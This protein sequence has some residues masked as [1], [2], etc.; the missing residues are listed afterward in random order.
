L[1]TTL[2]VLDD[3][4][5]HPGSSVYEAACPAHDDHKRSL[6]VKVGGAGQ[7][8]LFCLAFCRIPAITHVIRERQ[9]AK[10]RVRAAI[11]AGLFRSRC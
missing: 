7:I 8:F 3:V 10:R 2:A 9:R 1:H 6:L 5:H 4:F 11:R